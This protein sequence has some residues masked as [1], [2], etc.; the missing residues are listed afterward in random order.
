M[1]KIYQCTFCGILM[2]NVM[3]VNGLVSCVECKLG[4]DKRSDDEIDDATGE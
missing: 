1:T 2:T 3:W 4:D